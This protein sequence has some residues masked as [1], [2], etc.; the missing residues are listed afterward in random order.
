MFQK[1]LIDFLEQKIPFSNNK[2]F[3]YNK[4][5]IYQNVQK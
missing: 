2:F 5:N 4:E 3:V 1:N